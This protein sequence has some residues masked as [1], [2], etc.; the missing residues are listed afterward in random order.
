MGSGT[1]RDESNKEE[2]RFTKAESIDYQNESGNIC[3]NWEPSTGF[4]KGLYS[5]EIFNKG[6]IAGRGEFRLK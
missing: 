6:Y 1:I 3:M 5:V 2:M 4:D